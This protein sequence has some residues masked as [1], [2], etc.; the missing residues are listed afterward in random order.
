M[1]KLMHGIE[2]QSGTTMLYTQYMPSIAISK[3]IPGLVSTHPREAGVQRITA[4]AACMM[5][6]VPPVLHCAIKQQGVKYPHCGAGP[7]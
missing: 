5:V 2:H 6:C 4:A 1:H 7:C 3:L